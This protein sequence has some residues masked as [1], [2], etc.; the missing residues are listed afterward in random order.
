M[1]V[2]AGRTDPIFPIG[3]TRREFARLRRI[4]AAAGAPDK[5]RLVVGPEGH[6]FYADLAWPK[7][8]RE[9]NRL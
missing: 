4:Y 1:I 3:R 5:C 9:L 8:M 2:V 6:R 7:A